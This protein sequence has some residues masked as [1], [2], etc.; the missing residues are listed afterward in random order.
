MQVMPRKVNVFQAKDKLLPGGPC[1]KK[2]RKSSNIVLI[3]ALYT[4]HGQMRLSAPQVTTWFA[5]RLASGVF[6]RV[7]TRLI[8]RT[9]S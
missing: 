9:N 1:E 4:L 8:R 5:K 6:S 3:S 2:V 7:S